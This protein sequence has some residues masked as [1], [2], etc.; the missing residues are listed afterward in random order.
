MIYTNA[1]HFI[2][3]HVLNFTLDTPE[4][5]NYVMVNYMTYACHVVD[6]LSRSDVC[7]AIVVVQMVHVGK[8][9]V[10]SY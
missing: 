2:Y 3:K 7:K 5:V 6:M 9:Q 1:L 4:F 8:L 10:G